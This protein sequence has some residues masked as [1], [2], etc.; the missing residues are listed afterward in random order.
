MRFTTVQK[1]ICLMGPTASGKTATAFRLVDDDNAEIVSVDSAMIYKGMDIGTA[2]PDK[3]T[4]EKYPHHLVDIIDPARRYSVAEFLK[5]CQQAITDIQARGKLP[6][7][8]GGTM[9][10]YRCLQFG[11]STLPSADE[12]T[13]QQLTERMRQ[14]GL[15]DLY[16]QLQQVDP[17][18]ARQIKPTDAQRIQRALEVYLTSGVALS[19]LQQQA[20][21]ELPPYQFINIVLSPDDRRVLH[22]RIEQRFDAMLAQGFIEEVE[23]LYHRGDLNSDMPSMRCVGYRQAWQYLAGELSKDDMR[24]RAI[25]ATRQLAKR[26]LTWLRGKWSDAHWFNSSADIDLSFLSE[27]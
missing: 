15:D 20:E 10:Y 2:K 14:N 26:Q 21:V 25:I 11:L 22:Q 17:Q 1:V 3:T 13:R 8:V 4:L 18:S 7:L 19:Q 12:N 27:T 6:L 23:A 16:Q 24:E 5:N 9:M